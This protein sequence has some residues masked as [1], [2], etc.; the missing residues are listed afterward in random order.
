MHG[1]AIPSINPANLVSQ[2]VNSLANRV[3]SAAGNFESDLQSGNIAGAQS[4]LT[5]LEQKLAAPGSKIPGSPIASQLSQISSDLKSGDLNAAQTDFSSLRT[6]LSHLRTG[7]GWPASGSTPTP[8]GTS[9]ASSDLAPDPS[10]AALLSYNSLQQ[11]AFNGALNLSMPAT[12]P[13]LSVNS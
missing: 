6:G 2:A 12:F 3:S 4:F 11:N 13:S 7:S 1:L 9:S 8:A 10:L 5:A